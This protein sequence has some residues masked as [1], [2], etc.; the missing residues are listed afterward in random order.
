[1]HI[2]M[3]GSVQQRLRLMSG[4]VLFAFAA[5]HFL[6]HA[7][8]LVSLEAMHQAQQMRIAITRSAAGTVVL[9]SALVMHIA[10]GLYKIARRNT[11]R[12][13]PWEAVQILLGL[14]IPFFLFPH[15]V[16]TRIA[17]TFFNVGDSYLYELVR[18]WPESAIVQSL[19]LVLVWMHGC[20][21]LHY[22][23]RL[24]DSYR[25]LIPGLLVLAVA[26]PVL[27][28]TGFAVSGRITGDIMSDPQ[29]LAELKARS[30]WPNAEDGATL[31]WLRTG[32]RL[33]FAAAIAGALAILLSRLL[34][35]SVVHKTT[36]I[37]YVDGPTVDLVPGRTLLEVSRSAGITHAS[38]C[39][40]RGR[41]STCR[42]RIDKG[43]KK[44]PPPAG[45][46]AVTLRSIEAPENIRLA[47]QI[48]PIG[49]L[50]VA[51]IS[52]PA[53]PGPPQDSFSEIREFVAAHVRGVLAERPVDIGSSDAEAVRRWIGDKVGHPVPVPD[54]ATRGFALV[55]ARIDFPNNK[56]TATIVYSRLERAVTLFVEPTGP[57]A[58]L[59]MRG[60]RNGYHVLAWTDDK[61]AYV[62][63]SDIAAR[64][65][66]RLEEALRPPEPAL[67]EGARSAII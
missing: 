6:N 32:A 66:D 60:Q 25:K 9:A 1:M 51:L 46:E 57:V 14:A 13:P 58:S 44:L 45:A 65:L 11:W 3:R 31:A 53:T 4:L 34:A 54:L 29:S 59:A 38:V 17:H 22:W 7:L 39:G 63:V 12:M 20:L 27:A 36:R 24:S 47:C 37:S 42:V 19:L 8:G 2:Y 26:I 23:L 64:E 28:L 5:T 40:G 52:R 55:G 18:L 16:N 21:G 49:D 67:K 43:L 50:T 30:N 33:A 48:R 10:L 56:P 61:L 15:I 41:C 62:A 35:H